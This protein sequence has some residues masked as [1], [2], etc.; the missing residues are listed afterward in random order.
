[1]AFRSRRRELP[2]RFAGRLLH[3]RVGAF[4]ID[5]HDASEIPALEVHPHAAVSVK[6]FLDKPSLPRISELPS[7]L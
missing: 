4:Q 7:W 1:M 2:P 6:C 5:Q 3:S